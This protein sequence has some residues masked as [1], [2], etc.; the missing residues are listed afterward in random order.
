MQPS[1]RASEIGGKGKMHETQKRMTIYQG[2]RSR[3]GLERLPWG[4]WT[5]GTGSKK[6]KRDGKRFRSGRR[7]HGIKA[8]PAARLAVAIWVGQEPGKLAAT[9]A[10][11]Q[12]GDLRHMGRDAEKKQNGITGR[13]TSI[14]ENLNRHR[15]AERRNCC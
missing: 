9:E 10:G 12:L 1:S 14:Q 3:S 2:T 13:L 4:S 15:E 8:M 7:Q 11:V 5:R 6:N